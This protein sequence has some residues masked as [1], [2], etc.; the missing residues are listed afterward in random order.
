[1]IDGLV[2]WIVKWMANKSNQ[3]FHIFTNKKT[4]YAIQI[5]WYLLFLI[6]INFVFIKIPV[7]D[8]VYVIAFFVSL[9]PGIVYYILNSKGEII[10]KQSK[11]F[12]QAFVESIERKYKKKNK[13]LDKRN[14]VPYSDASMAKHLRLI[15]RIYHMLNPIILIGYVILFVFI[16]KIQI[17]DSFSIGGV[18]I[19]LFILL[20]MVL[21]TSYY[22]SRNTI[23]EYI[24][25]LEKRNL[26]LFQE[27]VITF[28]KN[29]DGWNNLIPKE[30]KE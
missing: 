4:K 2:K 3:L 8:T 23:Y 16:I 18:L 25:E 5:L 14:K 24:S 28:D 26:D 1:M 17:E 22:H 9:L 29:I 20:V 21:M 10:K 6:F 12:R 30:Q 7:S 13:K 27:G 15:Y 11:S 19:G